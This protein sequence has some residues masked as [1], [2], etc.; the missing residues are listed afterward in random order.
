MAQPREAP[1]GPSRPIQI[2]SV[3]QDLLD[4]AGIGLGMS[5]GGNGNRPR[6]N[7]GGGEY[8]GY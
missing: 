7:G 6:G 3:A 2:P 4:Q 8:R 1:T 5:A